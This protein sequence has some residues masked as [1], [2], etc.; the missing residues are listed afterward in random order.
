MNILT[1]LNKDKALE[2]AD[3]LDDL[4][5]NGSKKQKGI[6][7]L[8]HYSGCIADEAACLWDRWLRES[9][10][11]WPKFSGNMSYPV[12]HRNVNLYIAFTKLSKW[13]KRTQYGKD[14]RELCTFLANLIRSQCDE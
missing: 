9:F 13:D 5:V 12:R 8:S 1:V 2:L 14:R 6:C 4:S 11:V 7:Y 10:M 3:F